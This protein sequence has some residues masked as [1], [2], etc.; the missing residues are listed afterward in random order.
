MLGPSF[1]TGQTRAASAQPHRHALARTIL[2]QKS[3]TDPN[4]TNINIK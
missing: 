2:S 3:S 4:I 1:Q